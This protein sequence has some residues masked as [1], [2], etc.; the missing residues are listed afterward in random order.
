[1]G[2][3]DVTNELLVYLYG[4]VASL[5]KHFDERIKVTATDHSSLGGLISLAETMHRLNADQNQLFH[6]HSIDHINQNTTISFRG[7]TVECQGQKIPA[8]ECDLEIAR[9][10]TWLAV[11][12][13]ELYFKLEG[14]R[15]RVRPTPT[16][17]NAT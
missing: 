15:C 7:Q 2:G 8:D 4:L 12:L 13:V 3:A 16:T 14:T 9:M 5:R 10:A 1:M 17:G 11:H 6:L